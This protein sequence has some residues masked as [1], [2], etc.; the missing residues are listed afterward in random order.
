M[1]GMNDLT[2][3]KNE[4]E[5]VARARILFTHQSVGRDILAGIQRWATE[6]GTPLRIKPVASAAEAAPG[7]YH[8]E[9]G[10]N[11]DPESKCQAF[12]QLLEDDSHP[13]YDMALMKFCYLDLD[14]GTP[15][16]A[17]TLI[18]RYR[19]M[20]N[21]IRSVRPE[22]RLIHCTMPLRSDPQEWKTPVKRLLGRATYEDAGN[23]LRNLFNAECRKQH[24]ATSLF[25]IAAAESTLPNG[26]HSGFTQDGILFHTLANRYTHDGGHLNK[27]GQLNIA[28]EFIR[29]LSANLSVGVNST[30]AEPV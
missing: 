26:H 16:D 30:A 22:T 20:V 23:R 13:G 14:Q 11:G 2:Q 29:V 17:P 3:I 1:K 10:K 25:D 19:Q 8:A 15:M 9:T 4:L 6:T 21:D 18:R 12:Q 24:A 5:T 28:R 7:L 27:Q